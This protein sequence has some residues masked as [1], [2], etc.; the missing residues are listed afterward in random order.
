MT[1]EKV[2]REFDKFWRSL[3]PEHQRSANRFVARQAFMA[4][5][6]QTITVPRP[7][8]FQSGKWRVT[9]TATSMAAAKIEARK[10]LDQRAAKL[11]VKS[12]SAGWMLTPI[13]DD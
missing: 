9:V 5:T 13:S 3:P 11:C 8:R 10:K 12:P 1:E 7:Y 2:H 6:E 4:G